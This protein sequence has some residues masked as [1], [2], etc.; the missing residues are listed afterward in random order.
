MRI[1]RIKRLTAM[2]C[3][4]GIAMALSAPPKA[5]ADMEGSAGSVVEN[6]QGAEYAPPTETSQP[7]ADDMRE[8]MER[9]K[10]DLRKAEILAM[11]IAEQAALGYSILRNGGDPDDMALVSAELYKHKNSQNID[12]IMFI[13]RLAAAHGN[14]ALATEMFKKAGG[15]DPQ[16]AAAFRELGNMYLVEKDYSAA[17][18]NYNKALKIAPNGNGMAEL[19]LS[20]AAL[21]QG[22]NREHKKRFDRALKQDPGFM[23]MYMKKLE[24][25]YRDESFY[26]NVIKEYIGMAYPKKE[27]GK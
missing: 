15:I 16:N 9:K 5:A 3:A 20:L 27:A 19:G 4:A 10:K 14:N 11:P 8:L 18:E 13:G 17:K 22:D 6:P 26:D 25:Y 21:R 2:A 12:A 23:A 24:E 1:G 7:L